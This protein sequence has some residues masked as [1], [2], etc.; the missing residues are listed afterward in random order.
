M[1]LLKG[2]I[3]GG[4]I[5]LVSAT[6]YVCACIGLNPIFPTGPSW[7]QLLFYPGLFAGYSLYDSG[8]HVIILCEVAGIAVTGI[9]GMIVGAVLSF[10]I[11]Q[12]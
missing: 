2:S 8:L 1:S 12:F 3:C 5:G 10:A 11:Q 4:I 7:L 9:V 6:V